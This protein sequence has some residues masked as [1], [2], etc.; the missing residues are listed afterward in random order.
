M[1]E[2]IKWFDKASYIYCETFLL[3]CS[4]TIT[5]NYKGIIKINKRNEMLKT[6]EAANL[7]G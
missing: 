3:Y 5:K 4:L 2:D 6:N 7:K 1:T